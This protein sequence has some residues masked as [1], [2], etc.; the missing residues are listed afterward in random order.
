MAKLLVI[1]DNADLL[2]VLKLLLESAGHEVRT[3]RDG[4]EGLVQFKLSRPDLV[5]TDIVMPEKDG[6][7]VLLELRKV[8]PRPKIIAMSG[9]TLRASQYLQMASKIGAR[10]VLEKPFPNSVLLHAIDE[11]LAEP[12]EPAPAPGQGQ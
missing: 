4:A 9:G 5:L 3:A 7:A 10:R 6:V 11:V 8:T 1:D 12:A 2:P